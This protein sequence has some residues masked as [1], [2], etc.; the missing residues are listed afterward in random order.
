VFIDRARFASRATLSVCAIVVSLL[1]ASCRND[2]V[3]AG[4]GRFGVT[5]EV[6]DSVTGTRLLDSVRVTATDGVYQT[7]F[8]VVADSVFGGA[9]DRFG[10]YSVT[11]ERAGYVTWQR[12]SVR[13]DATRCGEPITVALKAL[14]QRP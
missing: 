1:A 3:C 9:T 14:L 6:R 10:T 2:I 13:V 4:V 12:N 7:Q 11:V 5:V 8:A